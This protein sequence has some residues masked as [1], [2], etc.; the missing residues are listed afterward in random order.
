[1]GRQQ[2]SVASALRTALADAA[3]V[4]VAG[5]FGLMLPRQD[6]LT[7]RSGSELAAI[8]IAF[9]FQFSK[10]ALVALLS[11]EWLQKFVVAE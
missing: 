1:M 10:Q 5:T 4:F 11:L 2:A 8:G 6:G 7:S 3:N 9:A